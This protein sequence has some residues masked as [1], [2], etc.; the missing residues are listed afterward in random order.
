MKI[1]EALNVLRGLDLHGLYV[2]NR[3]DI[4]KMFP[5]EQEKTLEKSLQRLVKA[6][7]LERVCKGIYINP[8]ASSK[9]HV[10]SKML[11]L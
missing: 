6:G 8:V 4:E 10:S 2:F 11:R 3:I 1:T 7:V 9:N 5:E